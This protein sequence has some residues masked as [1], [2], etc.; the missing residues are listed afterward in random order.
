LEERAERL[1]KTQTEMEEQLEALKK[2][3]LIRAEAEKVT[4]NCRESEADR[5]GT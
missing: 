4:D 2:V 3:Q 5:E 1:E